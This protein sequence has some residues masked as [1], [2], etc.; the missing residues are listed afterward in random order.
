LAPAVLSSG[1]VSPVDPLPSGISAFM[2]AKPVPA[3]V[4]ISNAVFLRN[5][6]LFMSFSLSMNSQLCPGLF[7]GRALKLLVFIHL[8]IGPLTGSV[9]PK[10]KKRVDGN[11]RPPNALSQAARRPRC[12][13]NNDGKKQNQSR[14]DAKLL[15]M[16]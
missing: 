11:R 14:P 1:I 13:H 7:R 9:I 3:I 10:N 12:C 15:I 8:G 5:A 16:R 6:R 2:T 4:A